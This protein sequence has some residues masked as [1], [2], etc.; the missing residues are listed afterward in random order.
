M[1]NF[2]S[3]PCLLQPGGR[4][5]APV[6]L[7]TSIAIAVA[8]TGC[9]QGPGG[10]AGEPRRT[11]PPSDQGVLGVPYL[12]GDAVEDP[13]VRAVLSRSPWVFISLAPVR[14]GTSAPIRDVPAVL[15]ATLDPV[16]SGLDF[17]KVRRL[18]FGKPR[19]PLGA[20]ARVE[21]DELR[22]L[23]WTPPADHVWLF[24]PEGSC[25]GRTGRDVVIEAPDDQTLLLHWTVDGC[26]GSNWAPVGSLSE[27]LPVELRY[28]VVA[29]SREETQTI[30]ARKST[31]EGTSPAW[32]RELGGHRLSVIQ[33]FQSDT[34]L[35]DCASTPPALSWWD[36]NRLEP[37][38]FERDLDGGV[39]VGAIVQPSTD[40]VSALVFSDL[41]RLRV[42]V[43]PT[44]PREEVDESDPI[45]EIEPETDAP[46]RWPVQWRH[47]ELTA[48][49]RWLDAVASDFPG[50]AFPC[51]P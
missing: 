37:I 26:M 22:S 13:P 10:S 27:A 18:A 19:P 47:V 30:E 2:R 33:E 8:S 24:G 40:E 38:E 9:R 28:E 43:P 35:D 7:V 21:A 44:A 4:R 48:T 41:D 14:D 49:S 5:I 17:L 3:W 36:G 15:G 1:T 34:S 51:E 16:S 25:R 20:S 11:A 32:T 50:V 42:A 31:E 6:L 23:G 45:S 46:P 12:V 29:P 39:L